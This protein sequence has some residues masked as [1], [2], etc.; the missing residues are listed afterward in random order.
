MGVI[1]V[2]TAREPAPSETIFNPSDDAGPPPRENNLDRCLRAARFACSSPR[3]PWPRPVSSVSGLPA[4]GRASTGP[5]APYLD[6]F[7]C[8]TDTAHLII[9]SWFGDAYRGTVNWVSERL[10]APP[11][12]PWEVT[13][14]DGVV[15]LV[16]HGQYLPH[17]GQPLLRGTMTLTAQVDPVIIRTARLRKAASRR[18]R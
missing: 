3:S 11:G 16:A 17:P 7:S 8:S 18:G 1:L 13:Y 14:S 15:R 9:V 12:A 10:V 6:R 2:G 5:V 4:E